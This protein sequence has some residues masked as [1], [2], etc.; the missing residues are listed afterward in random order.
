MAIYLLDTGLLIR[1]LRGKKAVVHLLR[2][3][4]A[5][6]RLSISA[7]T[8]TEIRAGM[9]LPEDRTTR[10][11]LA[12]LET[13]TLD[14]TIADRAGDLLRHARGQGRTLYLADAII[15]A[16]AAQ[17]GLTLVTLNPSDFE[18]LGLS[19]YPLPDDLA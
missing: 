12:R 6:S 4:G 8:R 1:H 10:R 3:L 13:I 5:R 15:A 16:T 11:L 2:G 7:I 9:R 19:L 17:R 18:G 14:Q